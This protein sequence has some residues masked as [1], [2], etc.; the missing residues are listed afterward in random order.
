MTP[1][2]NPGP[3]ALPALLA[4]AGILASAVQGT[5]KAS[6]EGGAV[7]VDEVVAVVSGK[8]QGGVPA[9]V[10]TRWDLEIECRLES[11]DRYGVHGVDRVVS[12]AMRASIFERM[13]DDAV[14]W[15]E[16]SRL[17]AAG[18]ADADVDAEIASLAEPS[19]GTEAFG[20]LLD[21]ASIPG[22]K[23]R[24]IVARR[25]VVDRYVLDN[26]RLSE[27]FLESD[28]EKAFASL[29]HPFDGQKLSDV[30]DE[31]REWLLVAKS[32]EHRKKLV[33]D[34][35]DRCIVWLFWSPAGEEA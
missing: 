3:A 6:S 1:I 12:Q 9:F 10:M 27:N 28:L 19:G 33:K 16:A 31:F 17:G 20:A 29:D 4:L 2:R 21:S 13:V 26:L 15:R 35:A 22:A 8:F 14:I 25:L 34:L 7:L 11:I 24:E 30:H 23:L 18:V 32:H 5:A